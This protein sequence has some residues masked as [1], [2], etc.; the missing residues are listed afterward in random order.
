MT[1]LTDRAAPASRR[2]GTIQ[3]EALGY[4]PQEACQTVKRVSRSSAGTGPSDGARRRRGIAMYKRIVLA[5]DLLEPTPSPEGADAGGGAGEDGRR[6]IE[7]GQCPAGHTG[8]VHGICAGRF[9]RR[10]GEAGQGG[11]RR[12]SWRRRSA[13]PSARAPR[14]G[15]AEFI[16]SSWKKRP[17]GTPTSS[18]S[19]RIVL[20]CRIT[21][22]AR[23]P[24]PSCAMP[25]VRCWW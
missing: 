25:N 22:W 5:V 3:A 12:D 14:P 15:R 21:C 24:R 13:A 6:R 2:T 23:T 10:A 1:I 19:V 11:A 18:L 20:S 16:T 17:N 7:A 4:L 9:R 8:H